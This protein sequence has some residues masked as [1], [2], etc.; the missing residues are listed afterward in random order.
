MHV[1]SFVVTAVDKAYKIV[2]TLSTLDRK[3]AHTIGHPGVSCGNHFLV[4]WCVNYRVKFDSGFCFV[5]KGSLNY[6]V[7]VRGFLKWSD[8]RTKMEII[9]GYNLTIKTLLKQV[10]VYERTAVR[11]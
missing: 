8:V 5:L 4:L 11:R 7:F 2:S 3:Y 1:L 6:F 10:K 9:S